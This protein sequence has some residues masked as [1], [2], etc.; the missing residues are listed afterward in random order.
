MFFRENESQN[1]LKVQL[2]YDTLG[3]TS[4]DKIVTW[5]SKFLSLKK[6]VTPITDKRDKPVSPKYTFTLIN[7]VNLVI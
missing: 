6:I 1:C 3:I 2:H 4:N 5:K 7:V